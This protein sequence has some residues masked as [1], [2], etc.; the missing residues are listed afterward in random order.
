MACAKAHAA[1]CPNQGS[2][3]PPD[4][5]KGLEAS[6]DNNY[7]IN[8]LVRPVDV[9]NV[10]NIA[11][12]ANVPAIANLAVDKNSVL[13]FAQLAV[14]AF[15]TCLQK[16]T[17]TPDAIQHFPQHNFTTI[18]Q[19]CHVPFKSMDN[20]LDT[21]T[22]RNIIPGILEQSAGAWDYCLICAHRCNID[23]L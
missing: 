8:N 9:V 4:K 13:P 20:M 2:S 1:C 14:N 17:L 22:K 12:L 19:I 10:A 5:S 15:N 3:Y 23:P 16:L 21:I 18:D 7:P 6:A 11:K